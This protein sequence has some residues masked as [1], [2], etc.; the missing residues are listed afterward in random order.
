MVKWSRGKLR[1]LAV[2]NGV[3]DDRDELARQAGNGGEIVRHAFRHGDH[4]IGHGV[5]APQSR[6]K[7]KPTPATVVLD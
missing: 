7:V 2:D 4:G 5:G 3:V 6:W 1:E